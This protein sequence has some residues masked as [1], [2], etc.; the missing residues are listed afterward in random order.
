MEGFV[1]GDRI[2]MLVDLK[3]GRLIFFRNGTKHGQGFPPGSLTGP[4]LPAAQFMYHG[5]GVR[6]VPNA[7]WPPGW[8]HMNPTHAHDETRRRQS[9]G[10]LQAQLEQDLKMKAAKAATPP[11]ATRRPPVGNPALGV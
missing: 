1:K 2:G 9:Q 3:V 10:P 4:V 11:Q 5:D 6:L 7:P 8:E